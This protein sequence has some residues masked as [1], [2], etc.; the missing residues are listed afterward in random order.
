[1]KKSSRLVLALIAISVAFGS[2][3]VCVAQQQRAPIVGGYKA[4]ATDAPDVVSAAEF[5]V[6]EQGRK[7]DS[8]IK[9]IAV[10]GAERQTVAGAN[11]RLCL[12]VEIQDEVNNV[13]ATLGVRVIVFRSLKNEYS[14]KI[15]EE[16]DCSEND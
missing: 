3:I 10:E 4:I 1:M 8:T 2:V 5:A 9:L 11:Y 16:E 15:W 7:V 14:L 6:G 12:K 13:D